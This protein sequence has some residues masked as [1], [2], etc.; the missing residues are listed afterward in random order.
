M[1]WIS[2]V[3]ISGHTQVTVD[4]SWLNRGSQ[5]AGET[6]FSV[7]VADFYRSTQKELAAVGYPC[8]FTPDVGVSG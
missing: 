4:H 6:I 5:I 1:L 2:V 7:E 8:G 3:L